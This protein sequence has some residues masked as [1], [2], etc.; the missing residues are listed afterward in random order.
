MVSPAPSAA[1]STNTSRLGPI[2]R[3]DIILKRSRQL[4]LQG[5]K[6]LAHGDFARCLDGQ[7]QGDLLHLP[8]SSYN[9]AI[10][11]LRQRKT[12][13]AIAANAILKLEEHIRRSTVQ[14]E[15]QTAAN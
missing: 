11:R 1:N 7:R 8:W 13:V 2:A 5:A 12:G 4:R 3:R 15:L 14:T 6:D 10:I 9:G